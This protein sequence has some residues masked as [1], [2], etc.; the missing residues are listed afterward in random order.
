MEENVK[1]LVKST[2][3]EE[4]KIIFT[5]S[6]NNNIAGFNN[7]ENQ[8]F[9][10]LVSH[11]LKNPF[12]TLLGFLD[13]LDEDFYELS[14]KE[15]KYYIT[16]IKKAAKLSYKYNER[17]FEWLYFK[18][19]KINLN[20][21]NLN[22]SKIITET[23]DSLPGNLKEKCKINLNVDRKIFIFADEH[24]IQKTF[25]YLI[26]NAIKYSNFNQKVIVKALQ[27]SENITIE[28]IDEGIG[29][30]EKDIGILFD[31]SQN[32]NIIYPLQDKGTGLG[33]ILS[34]LFIETNRGRIEVKSKLG[35]GSTFL[36]ELP[37]IN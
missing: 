20:F 37:I 22:L 27:T 10:S 33:V 7:I 11:N 6:G 30:S 36:I 9:I 19:S 16:E 25:Y 18:S 34:K 3:L 8:Q 2:K 14:D 21:Q 13:L 23:V 24:T 35:E 4:Q 26:E 5:K 12:A 31:Y 15:K 17:F 1:S 29:I 32:S 28:I